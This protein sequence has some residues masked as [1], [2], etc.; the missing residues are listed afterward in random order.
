MKATEVLS[1]EHRVIEEVLNTLESAANQL[2]SGQPIRPEFFFMATDFMRGF[3]DGCH[4]AKEEDVLF[5]R[6][7]EH[8]IATQGCPLGVMLAEHEA[9]RQYTRALRSAAEVMQA[10]DPS[11][12]QRAIMSSRSYISLLRLH[13]YKEDNI[14]FPMADEVIPVEQ[15][16]LVWEDFAHVEQF[17]TGEGVHEKYLALAKALGEEINT[18]SLATN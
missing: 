10:G 4:H 3:A 13:I 1:E 9:G 17:E 18:Y 8:G 16:P 6:M 11:G 7:E 15:H 5:N 12:R 14:L 2:E